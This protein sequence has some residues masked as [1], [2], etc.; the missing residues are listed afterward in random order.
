MADLQAQNAAKSTALPDGIDPALVV[1]PST[2]L[3][4]TSHEAPG[5]PVLYSVL[6]LTLAG[7]LFL[8]V[9]V[10]VSRHQRAGRLA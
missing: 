9:C 7:G 3:L 6:G 4:A 1:A 2:A 8:V 10:A 5:H